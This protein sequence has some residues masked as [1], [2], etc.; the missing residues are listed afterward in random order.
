MTTPERTSGMH[1][2]YFSKLYATK[3][4]AGCL[5]KRME[6]DGWIYGHNERRKWKFID[7]ARVVTVC[8]LFPDITP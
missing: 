4:Q 7:H 3:F 6:Q 5:A 8:D 2:V 1:W